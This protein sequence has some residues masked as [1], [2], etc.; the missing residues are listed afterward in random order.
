VIFGEYK[1]TETQVPAG[2][3]GDDSEETVTVS[4]PSTCAARLAEDPVVPDATFV[5]KLGSIVIQKLDEDAELLPGAG[6]TFDV[7][8]FDGGASIE[9]DDGSTDDQADD[10]DGVLC[11]DHVLK[12]TYKVTETQ[13]PAGYFGDATEAT[14]TVDSASTCAE[15][16]AADPVVYDATFTNKLGAIVIRKEGKNAS[17]VDPNDLLPGAGFTFDVN[18]FT[19]DSADIE[20][21]D[22]DAVDEAVGNNGII[23]IDHVLKG[24]YSVTESTVPANYNGD[25]DAE[26]IDVTAAGTCA[27]RLAADPVV[28]DA[29]FVNVPLSEIEVIF[30]SLAGAGVTGATIDCSPTSGPVVPDNDP[31]D[32]N[33][34]DETYTDLPP[35]TYT[36]TIVIDP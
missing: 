8:P 23:C 21:L 12:G 27:D 34:L 5:N 2:Y 28:V 30:T 13:V 15:R 14:I 16:L 33:D 6:Y 18:P 29:L 7:N 20:I 1:I 32:F 35:G 11:I 9:I 24:S 25:P 17:T 3:F 22:G 36:C 4:S 31:L 19:G 26:T 10:D